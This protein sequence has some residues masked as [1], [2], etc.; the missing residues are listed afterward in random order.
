MSESPGKD[1][2]VEFLLSWM[3]YFEPLENIV[4]C[5]GNRPRPNNF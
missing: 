2:S 5:E 4:G 1:P 3:M